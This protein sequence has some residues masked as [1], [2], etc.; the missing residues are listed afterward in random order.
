MVWNFS[1]LSGIAKQDLEIFPVEICVNLANRE[2]NA[3]LLIYKS[4]HLNGKFPVIQ[5]SE[6]EILP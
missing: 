1:F 3:E 6:A 5:H 4:G 2:K